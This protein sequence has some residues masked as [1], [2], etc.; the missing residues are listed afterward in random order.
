MVTSNGSHQ[1]DADEIMAATDRTERHDA[2][3]V[4]TEEPEISDTATHPDMVAEPFDWNAV[5]ALNAG[6]RD[7]Y[8]HEFPGDPE[9]EHIDPQATFQEAVES[10]PKGDGHDFYATTGAT[11]SIVR[12]RVF[13]ELSKRLDCEYSDIYDAWLHRKSLDPTLL[14]TKRA[15]APRHRGHARRRRR[16]V[17]HSGRHRRPHGL[18][19]A[20]EGH[21]PRSR[22]IHRHRQP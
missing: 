8:V 3:A 20:S 10:F 16:I 18:R 11:D 6:I 15:H 22:Q 7:W 1:V 17:H 19:P 13:E 4:G 12:E 5:D 2:T 14:G 21:H 9:G